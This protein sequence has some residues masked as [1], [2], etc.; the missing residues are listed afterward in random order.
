M[1]T[2][3]EIVDYNNPAHAQDLVFL[4]NCYAEDPMGG[5]EPLNDFTKENLASTLA[6]VPHAFSLILYADNQPAGLANCILGFSTF[7]CKPLVNI[8]DLAVH[9][10]FRGQGFGKM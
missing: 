1:Q 7:A 9:A 5:N 2:K 10:D 3:I 4:L 6:N 8:H